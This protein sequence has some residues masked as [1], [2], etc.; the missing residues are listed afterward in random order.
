M[1]IFSV[2]NHE[3]HY[4][5]IGQG[6]VIVFGHGYLWDSKM[7][8][9]QINEL[10]QHYR[11]IVPDF[12]GHGLSSSIPDGVR[13]LT[14]YA[15]HVLALLDSLHIVQFSLAGL[16]LG[17]LWSVEVTIRAPQRVKSLAL[18][19][20]F[21]GL[22]PEVNCI[23]YNAM[24]DRAI[25][26]NQFSPAAVAQLLPLF[27]ATHSLEQSKQYVVEFEHRLLN[28]S[29]QQVKMWVKVGKMMFT[30]PER[31]DDVEKFS[32]PVLILSG[33]EDR[34]RPP[35]ES[36]LM[37]D[38]ISGSELHILANTGHVSSVESGDAVNM[39]L[40]AFFAQHLR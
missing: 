30:R 14:D 5:D 15:E 39:H 8:Q 27:F 35:L 38:S 9:A 7:W 28:A 13:N 19:N 18:L 29:A 34:V 16:S 6:E 17:G 22:E 26:E 2:G 32:L 12:W 23:K 1:P 11:C 21:V 33:A 24:F 4:Q 37:N 36:Y 31:F 20:T 25:E 3:M 40:N 10:S